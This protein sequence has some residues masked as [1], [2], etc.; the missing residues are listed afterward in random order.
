MGADPSVSPMRGLIERYA[1][2]LR[3]LERLYPVS[4]SPARAAR[5]D[6]HMAGAEASLQ[7]VELDG[8]DDAGRIDWLLFRNHLRF[9]RSQLVHAQRKAREIAD[10]LPFA[11]AI[12][13]LEEER[14][15]MTA[16]QEA[17][18]CAGVVA[19][20]E[21]Q[22][23]QRQLELTEELRR[24]GGTTTEQRKIAGRRAAMAV[25]ELRAALGEWSSFYAEW[26]PDFAW[27]LRQP[28]PATDAALAAY[29]SFLRENLL[30]QRPGE[31]APVVGD[32]I[33]REALLSHL[34]AAA[35][36]SA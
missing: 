25:D 2:D 35:I 18:A 22:A 26:H 4:F 34:C 28:V 30:G 12:I 6:E 8:L 27:W 15:H 36:L 16:E 9:E 11:S 33:G 24:G 7:A 32:P 5:L 31:E 29:A 20:V 10:L 21:K 14:R 13:Q 23:V 1:A 3:A 19:G 17:R